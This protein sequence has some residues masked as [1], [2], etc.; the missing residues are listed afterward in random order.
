MPAEETK[1]AKTTATKTAATKRKRG[2]PR[3]LGK[4]KRFFIRLPLEVYA[5]MR[6]EAKSKGVKP[7][8]S[9]REALCERFGGKA[10]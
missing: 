3:I 1:A 7:T 4:H 8:E 2:R 10:G 5:A 9:A 6:A